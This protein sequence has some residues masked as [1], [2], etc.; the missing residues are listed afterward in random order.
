MDGSNT[1]SIDSKDIVIIDNKKIKKTKGNYCFPNFLGKAMASVGQR[2]Q[3]EA[4]LLS[5][6]LILIGLM[7]MTIV[8]IFGTDFSLLIKILAGVN[9]VAAFIFLSSHLITTFQQYQSYLSIVG[10]LKDENI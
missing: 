3:F 9:G 5:M 8:T 1:S 10:I 2:I 7:T 6:S 4:S